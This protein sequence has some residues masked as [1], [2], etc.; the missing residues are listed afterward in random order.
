M[1]H[2]LDRDLTEIEPILDR[3]LELSKRYLAA[4]DT[5]PPAR[6][7]LAKSLLALPEIG[8]GAEDTIELFW[9]RY[10]CDIPAS[11]G[12]R[13][14]GFV[15]GGT[16]PAALAG[17]WLTSVFDLNLT[18]AANSTAPNIE[19]EAIS[20]FRDLLGL[21]DSFSGTFVTGATMSNFS[22]LA[23]GREWIARQFGKSIA[24][25]GLQAL[26]PFKVLSGEMHSSGFKVLAMLGIGRKSFQKITT[27]PGNREA[28][29]LSALRSVL[30]S[31][32]GQPCLVVANAGT[33]NT[34]DFDDLKAIGQLKSEFDFWLHVDAAFGGFAACSPSYSHLV[35]G[36]QA[37]DS[38]TIDAH[39]WLNVP[40]D[41]AVIFTRHRDLQVAVFQNSAA[42][43]G[44]LSEPIDFVHLSPENSRRLR[45]LPVWFTLIAYGRS[46]YREIVDRCCHLAQMLGEKIENSSRFHLLAPVRMN[47]VCFTIRED[48]SGDRIKDYLARLR[49]DGRVFLTPTVYNDVP[50][51]RAAFSNWRTQEKDL[52]IA[53]E[54]MND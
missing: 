38:I 40:Y 42:Y 3:I 46:G 1:N 29:D 52:E 51:I 23:M 12:S 54:A 49:D 50:G 21:P 11:N 35:D 9:Q 2:N 17:D 31:L 47:V 13:F 32:N 30:E 20:L 19:C 45:A 34:V 8:H 48:V 22:G 7:F 43:L 4:I 6:E 39:K 26:P 14:W 27:L 18:S 33:V 10:G 37:A 16:T 25:D 53:W 5:L 36:I 24:S 15:T 41:S 28:I 44:E